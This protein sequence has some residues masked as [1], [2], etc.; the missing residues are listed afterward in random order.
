MAAPARGPGT[1]SGT[2]AP[3]AHPDEGSRI[4]HRRTFALA[5]TAALVATLVGADVD[6]PAGR[7]AQATNH[8]AAEE[9]GSDATLLHGDVTGDGAQELVAFDPATGDW[10]V[11][12]AGQQ[13]MQAWSSFRTRRGWTEHLV[14]D[15][16]GDGRDDVL[17][18]HEGTGRWWLSRA[19]DDGFD[20]ELW[21]TYGTRTGWDRHL[22]GDF[23]GDGR[24]DLASYHPKNGTWWV[25]RGTAGNPSP[26][27]WTT[28]ATRRG[29]SDHL[30][31]DF[32]GD[33][34]DDLA[35]YHPGRGVWVRS[36]S[37]GSH[38]APHRWGTFTTKR[39]WHAHVAAAFAGDGRDRVASY[40]RGTGR[41]WVSGDDET[42]DFRTHLWAT[43]TTRLGWQAHLPGDVD[44]DGRDDLVSYHPNTGSVW[45]SSSTGTGFR[46]ARWATYATRF[47]WRTH[48]VGDHDG[49]GN[50]D[51]AGHHGPTGHVSAS[52]STGDSFDVGDLPFRFAALGDFGA[53]LTARDTLRTIR[54]EGA[55]FTLTLGDFSYGQ[56]S[57]EEWCSLVRGVVGDRH[58][59]QLLAG[60]HDIG[61]AGQPR[62]A[63]LARLLACLP[64][65]MPD[66]AGEYGVQYTIDH[67]G[68]ARFI[69]ITPGLTIDGR[70]RTYRPDTSEH[71]WLVHQIDQAREAG[72]DWVVVGMHLNCITIGTKT[73]EIG[74]HLLTEL[75]DRRVDLVLQGHE[76]AYLRSHQLHTGADCPQIRTGDYRD[77]C[78]TK[79]ADGGYDRGEG[80]LLVINGTG[81]MPLRDLD[82]SRPDEPF[83]ADWHGRNIDPVHGPTVVEVSSDHLQV[84][85]VAV[86][87]TEHDTFTISTAP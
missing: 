76:H 48:L 3:A 44:G 43:F 68:L 38:F 53:G 23:D 58:P 12:E 84:R 31:G 16:T 55:E 82:P 22:V 47:N 32:D 51:L 81:G 15:V 26:V 41:W 59:F 77:A 62:H 66:T 72:I 78:V 19:T 21:L 5:V 39:G 18:Y 86:D 69:A 13:A 11:R 34:D 45:V 61:E 24:G 70:E 60:N 87:G 27:L 67:G 54:R 17:S 50:A 1:G 74:D 37:T 30:V 64:D 65:R 52:P 80:P 85:L 42:G 33:G 49:D 9:L 10:R 6:A 63:E 2:L 25:V 28:F 83:F 14:A 75:A 73:C 20:T 4:V 79:A 57:E 35:H 36:R 29:W 56:V 46:G 71:A 40:H 7:A 8:T